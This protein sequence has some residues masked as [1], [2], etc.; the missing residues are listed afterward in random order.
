MQDSLDDYVKLAKN[1]QSEGSSKETQKDVQIAALRKKECETRAFKIVE[2]SIEGK[3]RPEIFTRCLPYI[4]Q[5]HYQDIVEERAITKLC[6]YSVCGRKIPEM[7]KKQFYI[8]TKHNKVYDITDRKNYCSNFCY[9]ASIHIKK[10]IDDSPLWL[11]KLDSIPEYQFLGSEGGGLPGELI[12]QGI[13]KPVV[14][15]LFTSVGSF[16]NVSLEDMINKEKGSNRDQNKAK[17]TGNKKKSKLIKTM[18]TITEIEQIEEEETTIQVKKEPVGYNPLQKS[19]SLPVIIENEENIENK[20]ESFESSHSISHTKTSFKKTRTKSTKLPKIDIEDQIK[21]VVKEW[22][23]LESLIFLYGEPKIKTVLNEKKLSE[24]FE[25][26]QIDNLQ[27]D[28]QI[29]YMD[30]CRRLNL[31]EMA[32]E[33]FDNSLIGTKLQP[34][35]DYAKIKQENKELTIKVKCFFSGVMLE[36]EDSNFPSKTK[37]TEENKDCTES[38]V[39]LP[40]VDVNSQKALRR[41]IFLTAVNKSMQQLLQGLR[42]KFYNT[43]LTDLQNLVKT[44]NLNADNIVFRPVVWNYISII[45]LNILSIRDSDIKKVLEEKASQ[46]YIKLEMSI[47]PNKEVIIGHVMKEVSD[48]DLFI[49]HYISSN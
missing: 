14:E 7:P 9:K 42:I 16:T 20:P 2:F 18:Q 40:L 5:S 47:L 12:D 21:K 38:P 27:R 36:K 35:P 13:S 6:G 39:V 48:I 26:L 31:R 8:S 30:I 34:P 19:S 43:I 24:Y 22:L 44:F 11:R 17:Q 15:P 29:K 25:K 46:E 4:N 33:K 41:K 23:T 3:L 32:D 1:I 37:K 28:Q 10:Q 49:E 45:L